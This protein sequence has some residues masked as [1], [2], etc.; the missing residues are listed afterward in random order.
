MKRNFSQKQQIC[1]VHDES[2]G[3]RYEKDMSIDPIE[4]AID[5]I[6]VAEVLRPVFEV[7]SADL[8]LGCAKKE[9]R[10]KDTNVDPPETGWHI[11]R[12]NLPLETGVEREF[13]SVDPN[14]SPNFE[15]A[16]LS[17]PVLI[18]WVKKAFNQKCPDSEIYELSWFVFDFNTVRTRIFSE[19]LLVGQSMMK[20][21]Y[22]TR[23]GTYECSY[24]LRKEQDRLWVYSSIANWRRF[25]TFRIRADHDD[26]A[27]L[28][29]LNIDINWSWWTQE[30]FKERDTLL[31]IVP[32]IKDLGW[33][34]KFFAI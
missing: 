25:P 16:T 32:Q 26:W 4:A 2:F 29:Y 8:K 13:F 33:Q 18:D 21:I 1:Y 9:D 28:V 20:T 27:K 30:G 3:F 14:R 12:A 17:K 10:H 24:P 6:N 7:T 31:K 19:E 5:V 22:E 11:R 23:H 15:V 34:L